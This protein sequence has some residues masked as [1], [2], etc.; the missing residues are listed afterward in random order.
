MSYVAVVPNLFGPRDWFCGRQF[1]Q[2][3]GM[4]WQEVELRR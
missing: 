1:F 3:S 2:T 4:G